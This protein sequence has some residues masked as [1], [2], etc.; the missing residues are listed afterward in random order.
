VEL[1]FFARRNFLTGTAALALAFGAYFASIVL[2]PL[3]LQQY[4]GYTA[5]L[6]GIALAPV[7]LLAIV[8]TPLVGRNAQRI[9]PRLVATT[10]MVIFAV[11]A[12]MRGHFTPQADLATIMLPTILQGAAVACFFVPLIAIVNSDLKPG[13]LAAGSGLTQFVRITA[14]SFATSIVTT[15]WDHRASLHH[16]QLAEHLTRYDANATGV[17][18]TMQSAGLST[19]QAY[20]FGNQ[21]INQKA[22]TMAALDVVDVSAVLLVLLIP[23]IWM[24]H[25]PA[26]HSA[27]ADAGGAH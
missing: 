21:L 13:E 14:G 27:P 15:F 1:R 4:M 3:W 25:R 6:A 20:A 10:S 17:F 11:V 12:L 26:A 5:T 19:D 8:L 7:G 2:L 22:F 23:V 18:S 9:D 24:A 16:A